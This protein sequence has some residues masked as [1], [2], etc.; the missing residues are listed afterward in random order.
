MQTVW[1]AELP[2]DAVSGAA[3]WTPP[4]LSESPA[5]C[6]HQPYWSLSAQTDHAQW[7]AEQEWLRSN[8]NT[9]KFVITFINTAKQPAYISSKMEHILASGRLQ[10]RL[11]TPWVT[12]FLPLA[13]MPSH[14]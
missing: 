8:A 4:P 3:A 12:A 6:L 7:V 13:M 1:S 9:V 2:G 10:G 5:L 11:H 14:S